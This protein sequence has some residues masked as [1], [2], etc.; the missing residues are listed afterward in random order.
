MEASMKGSNIWEESVA[1]GTQL[2]VQPS[3]SMPIQLS[4]ITQ[5]SNDDRT[6]HSHTSRFDIDINSVSNRGRR[7]SEDLPLP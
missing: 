1:L 2:G 4:T 6:L 5:I 7:A 3:A